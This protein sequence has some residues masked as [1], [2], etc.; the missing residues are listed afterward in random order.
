MANEIIL[1]V[2]LQVK[3]GSFLDSY[4]PGL[5]QIDQT[6]V[7]R[8]GYVQNVGASEEVIDFGDVVTNGYALLRN[9][10]DTNYVTFGPESGGAM[11][12]FG[13]LKA[14]EMAIFRVAPTVVM[15]AQAEN[16]SVADHVLLDVRLYED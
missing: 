13:K 11:V 15:R 14:G 8:G 7:G 9:L 3:N 12:V 5:L 10:S 2:G 6:S 1:S 4:Q 16:S